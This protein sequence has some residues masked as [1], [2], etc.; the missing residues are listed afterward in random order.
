[1]SDRG[2]A[3]TVAG[4]D[5]VRLIGWLPVVGYLLFFSYAAVLYVGLGPNAA[6][7]ALFAVPELLFG[8]V[9][10]AAFRAERAAGAGYTPSR[11]WYVAGLLLGGTV[12]A[13]PLV[14]V[15]YF[16]RRRS[17]TRRPAIGWLAFVRRGR[18]SGRSEER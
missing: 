9:W 12:V 5:A 13:A 6:P 18:S 1:M 17:K 2:P 8:L 11:L 4:V 7:V 10:V 15:A 14:S 3:G 16:H